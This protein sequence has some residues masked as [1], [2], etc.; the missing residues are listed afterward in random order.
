M[1][2]CHDYLNDYKF[3]EIT[4]INGIDDIKLLFKEKE[5]ISIC[6]VM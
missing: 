5:Q 3:K 1:M 4:V 2:D 6:Y